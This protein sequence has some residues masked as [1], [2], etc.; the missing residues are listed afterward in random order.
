[1]LT[2]PRSTCPASGSS[3][4]SGAS[5]RSCPSR[6]V[7]VCVC[8]RRVEHEFLGHTVPLF[9]F[10]SG[11]A[12][13]GGRHK[14]WSA[15]KIAEPA[16]ATPSST[17]HASAHRGGVQMSQV[18]PRPSGSNGF[19]TSYDPTNSNSPWLAHRGAGKPPALGPPWSR[20]T[21]P[22]GQPPLRPQ[23]VMRRKASALTPP[24]RGRSNRPSAPPRAWE[25]GRRRMTR[26]HC[27][28]P[29]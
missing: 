3:S 26:S 11:D 10:R 19:V 27:I 1:M 13:Q 20:P 14:P 12:D 7:C 29:C 16:A 18:S 15:R 24:P 9:K 8:A 5:T 25:P 28:A 23:P 4:V 17:S 2:P 6:C 21:V 22:R